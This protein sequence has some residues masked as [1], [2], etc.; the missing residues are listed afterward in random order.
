MFDEQDA[1]YSQQPHQ[2]MR[3][4]RLI[5][6]RRLKQ[7]VVF[8][9]VLLFVVFAV[10]YTGTKHTSNR[11]HP[12]DDTFYHPNKA[13]RPK[14][15]LPPEAVEVKDSHGNME[16][17]CSAFTELDHCFLY[18]DYPSILRRLVPPMPK[19]LDMKEGLRPSFVNIVDF[20]LHCN[21]MHDANSEQHQRIMRAFERFCVRA[22]TMCDPLRTVDNSFQY[23]QK[24]FK[25]GSAQEQEI[26]KEVKEEAGSMNEDEMEALENADEADKFLGANS[27]FGGDFFAGGSNQQQ[28][29]FNHR[30]LSKPVITQLVK[31]GLLGSIGNLTLKVRSPDVA[32]DIGVDES[33]DI[34]IPAGNN[35]DIQVMAETTWGALH[36]LNT[37]LSL[38]K[39]HVTTGLP[40]IP[41][42]PITIVDRPK[43][44]WRG[45][46]L[47][48]ARH[49]YPVNNITSLLDAME[50]IHLNVFHW[51]M[52]DD[53][54]FPLDLDSF[55]SLGEKGAFSLSQRYSHDDIK[56]IVRHAEDRGI[57][58]IPEIDVPGHASSW[59]LGIPELKSCDGGKGPL[60]PLSDETY[61]VIKMVIAEIGPLF[62]TS[63]YFHVGGDEF[64]RDCWNQN[65]AIKAEMNDGGGYNL[66]QKLMDAAFEAVA[67]IGK[68]PI[69]WNDIR[70]SP[71]MTI[72]DN[73]LVQHW[74]LW[75]KFPCQLRTVVDGPSPHASIQSTGLYLDWEIDL[76]DLYSTNLLHEDS[77]GEIE[78]K[79]LI[80]GAEAAVW[81]EN[82]GPSN[83]FCRIFPRAIAYAERVWSNDLALSRGGTGGDEEQYQQKDEPLFAKNMR[84]GF[85]VDLLQA[86]GFPVSHAKDL[87]DGV[88]YCD[89]LPGLDATDESKMNEERASKDEELENKKQELHLHLNADH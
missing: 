30:M 89:K 34:L 9:P 56:E 33:F 26:E 76:K 4:W 87:N 19:P 38:I 65:P 62:S 10:L 48:T 35:A 74:K 72:P 18:P 50:L 44:Q 79:N 47:D 60:N 8:V 64:D 51:H 80:V 54:S 29:N 77:C 32:L 24:A 14:A 31:Q 53:Q 57:V 41:N 67:D 43:S 15:T 36:A 20:T 16:I 46:L 66:V 81:S 82:I 25:L 21:T 23:A 42:L 3:N 83:Y 28:K 73:A 69:V 7:Y 86:I 12:S 13:Y 37:I 6:R 39:R 71:S 1:Y 55:P 63:K 84:L 45:L 58:V 27:P 61:K 22:L 88:G 5:P 70:E 75:S 40:A 11:P 52:T 49:F 68:T 17:S 85:M 59:S 78:H 2:R